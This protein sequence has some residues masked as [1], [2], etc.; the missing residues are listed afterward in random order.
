MSFLTEAEERVKDLYRFR[1][2][3][4]VD[5]AIEESS[6]RDADI[7]AKLDETIAFLDDSPHDDESTNDAKTKA[8]LAYLRGHSLNVTPSHD[9][10]AEE[11]LSRA[12]KLDPTL[13]SAW[14]SLG[15]CFWKAGNVASARHCFNGVLSHEKDK[16]ALRNLSMVLRQLSEGEER[17]KNILLS[18]ER[19]KEAIA[20]DVTDGMSWYV[21]GNAYL[22]LFFAGGQPD[23][24]LKQCM[25]AYARAEKDP[26]VA[27]NADLHFNRAVVLKHEEQ[28]NAAFE[29][30]AKAHSLDP[31]WTEPGAA[32]EKLLSYLKRIDEIMKTKSKLKAKRLASMQSSLCNKDLGPYTSDQQYKSTISGKNV[33]L[34]AVQLED[35]KSGVNEERVILGR[36][37]G[38]IMSDGV[39]SLSIVLMTR[40][41][42]CTSVTLYNVAA[43]V[44]FCIGDAV[45]IPEPKYETKEVTLP[46]KTL[47]SF[48]SIRVDNPLT[49]AVNRR[50]I[51]REK[52]ALSALNIECKSE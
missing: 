2:L 5:H 30:F 38:Q 29:G 19:A 49:L 41:G 43:G 27:N 24:M 33:C 34:S 50:K 3:Y 8:R 22:S 23:S 10:K 9:P 32:T 13:A 28:Y 15:E 45:A 48:S 52:L 20:L 1:D 11:W 51:G 36:I 7:K 40:E 21:L 25:A 6:R 18:V 39:P 35:L 17:S 31:S 46:D 26:V 47:L 16:V 37:V 4:F 14:N 42:S 12:V 44:G